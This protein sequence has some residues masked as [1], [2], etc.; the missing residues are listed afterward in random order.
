METDFLDR[1]RS[2]AMLIG[3]SRFTDAALTPVPAAANS[4]DKLKDILTDPALGGWPE[5]RVSVFLDPRETGAFQATLS[6]LAGTAEDGL[7]LYFVGHGMLSEMSELCLALSDTRTD[8]PEATGLP[9]ASVK[10]ILASSPAT[11]KSVILDCCYSGRAIESLSSGS[12]ADSTAVAGVTTLTAADLAAHVVPLEQ[13]ATACTSFTHHLIELIRSGRPNSSPTV[14]LHDIY[15]ALKARLKDIGLPAPNWRTTDTAS[16]FPMARNVAGLPMEGAS[17]PVGHD[18]ALI[19][20]RREGKTLYDADGRPYGETGEGEEVQ[21]ESDR[22]WWPI[23][24]SRFPGLRALVFVVG[25]Q[26]NRVREVI[27]I[28]EDETGES[29]RLALD[30]SPPLT[31]ADIDLRLPGLPVTLGTEMPAVRGK[32]R[33]YRAF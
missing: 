19:I 30:V 15:P 4:V 12:I 27:G 24:R 17:R 13:Q 11:V 33:E 18:Q 14:T 20:W 28:D 31:P 7:L 2:R 22:K 21:L 23:A 6:D 8:H 9:Y 29:S 32:L 26:V 16:M 25:G 10:K 5:D 3:V 1:R